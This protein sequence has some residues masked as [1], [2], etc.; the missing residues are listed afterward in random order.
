MDRQT[1]RKHS[2]TRR[3]EGK[4]WGLMDMDKG[5][6]L[7]ANKLFIKLSIFL[8]YCSSHAYKKH[9]IIPLGTD[10][11]LACSHTPDCTTD[12]VQNLPVFAQVLFCFLYFAKC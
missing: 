10:C 1:D 9:D 3:C 6:F 5:G 11:L 12:Q 2:D 7:S 4:A 8:S